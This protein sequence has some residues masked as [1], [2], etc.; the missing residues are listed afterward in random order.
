MS[1]GT[2]RH[3]AVP[4]IVVEPYYRSLEASRRTGEA[5]QDYD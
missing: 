3:V 4:L 2:V 1:P 5:H